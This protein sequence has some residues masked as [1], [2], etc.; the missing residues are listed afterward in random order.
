MNIILIGVQGSGKGTQASKLEQNTGWKHINVG[1]LFRQ[2]MANQTEIGLAAKEYIE[3]GLLVPD[4]FV[5]DMVKKALDQASQGFILDG[6]PRNIN[7][8]KFL[9]D[10]FQIDFVFFLE[11]S[12]EMAKKRIL[13]RLHCSKCKKD[14]NLLHHPPKHTGKC[15]I[16][17][18]KL[19]RRKDDTETAI[20]KR[21]EKFH[22]ETKPV[23]ELFK[24]K[25]LLY[26]INANQDVTS[27]HEDI[28]KILQM[29]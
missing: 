12:D 3:K 16:C 27:I 7:Q 24:T 6:F 2:H 26:K 9:L 20:D 22:H 14:Y 18:G 1:D 17:G 23:I 21:I 10:H 4:E 19:I 28:L 11:L 29:K 13:A 15:D 8:E 25:H 5:L